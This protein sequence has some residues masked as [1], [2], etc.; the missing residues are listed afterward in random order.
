MPTTVLVDRKGVL[1]WVHRSYVPGAENEY[2]H[3][4]RALLAEEGS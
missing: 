3:Q 4:V 2:L 1:R